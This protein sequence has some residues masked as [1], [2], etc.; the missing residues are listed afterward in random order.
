MGHVE[1]RGGG[2]PAAAGCKGRQRKGP[3]RRGA[4]Q[5][6]VGLSRGPVLAVEQALVDQPLHQPAD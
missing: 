2:G 1:R 3:G 5:R 6:R 4:G